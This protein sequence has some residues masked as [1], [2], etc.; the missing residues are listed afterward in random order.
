MLTLIIGGA[1]S[2]KSRF[3]E[4]LVTSLP[5]RKVYLATMENAGV[6]NQ[7]R[8]ATHRQMRKGKG[9]E[10]VEC[11]VNLASVLLPAE[12]NVLLEDLPNLVANEMFSSAGRGT[13]HLLEDLLDL[14]NRCAHLTVV[15]GELF[16][17]GKDYG[18]ETLDYIKVLAALHI[19]L[20][21]H[22]GLV[23]EVVSS[24]PNVL[25]GTLP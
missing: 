12:A 24:V 6:E 3:A 10:T 7:K 18:E 23:V 15:T 16:S 1:S 19:E 4:E 17:G 22:A 14:K 2:G 13:D 11:P 21:R 8:I 20:A 25:K 5:G 9:F